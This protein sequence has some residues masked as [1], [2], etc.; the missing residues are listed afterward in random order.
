MKEPKLLIYL[1]LICIFNP[2]VN[3]FRINARRGKRRRVAK[4]IGT[5]ASG[6]SCI[7]DYMIAT[8]IQNS[9]LR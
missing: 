6:H 2:A 1:I 4:I 7:S 9:H 3:I 5:Q 8:S